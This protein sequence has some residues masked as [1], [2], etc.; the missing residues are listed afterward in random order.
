MVTVKR[1]W[2]CNEITNKK[3]LR[4]MNRGFKYLPVAIFISTAWAAQAQQVVYSPSMLRA[5]VPEGQEIDT[6]FFQ[7]GFD[8]VPGSYRFTLNVNGERHRV[9]TYELREYGN[10]LELVFQKKDIIDLPLKEKVIKDNFD[11]LNSDSEIF[12]ISSKLEGVVTTV[13]TQTMSIDISIP[14]IYLREDDGWVDVAPEDIW[15]YGETG[16]VINYNI[17][18]L[19]Q[20]SRSDHNDQSSLYS[21]LSGRLNLGPWR[22]YTSGAISFYRE[23][24]DIYKDRG[25]EWDLW[26]TYL[27]RDIPALKGTVEL[28]EITTSSEIFE[29]IPLRGLRLA[30][31]IQMLPNKDRTYAPIIEGIA[32]TNAQVLIRQNGH[33]VY[34]INVAAGPFRLENLPSFG[35]YGDLEVVIKEADGTERILNVPYSTVPNMLREGQFRYDLNFG[36]YYRK[37]DS[38][39]IDKPLVLLGTLSYGLPGDVTLY[40]GSL[41]SEGYYALALGTGLSLGKYGAL[42]ADV[43]QSKNQAD[44]MRG[45]REGNGAAWRVRYEKTLN[46]FGTTINLANYQYR[47]GNYM[48]MEDYVNYGRANS[49]FLS[50]HGR[51]KSRWQIAMSQNLGMY[52]SFTLGGDYAQY[53]GTTAD[54]KSITAGYGT[55]LKGIGVSVNYSRNYIKVGERSNLHWDSSHSI[56]LNLNIP[57]ALFTRNRANSVIDTTNI[58]YQARMD[59]SING[60]TTYRQSVVMNGFSDDN[61]WNWSLSQEMGDHKDR[62][63][64][65]SL[66]FNGDRF[67]AN[68]GIDHS[69]ISNSYQLGLNGALVFHKSGITSTSNA[70]DSIAIIE[71]PGTS[72]VKVSQYFDTKTDMFGNSVLS[73]L[74][75]YSKNE[76]EIDPATLPDGAILLD[77]S[78]KTVV[79]TAGAIV[80]VKYPIRFGRQ[81]VIILKNSEGNPIP[82]GSIV[83][84][85]DE[86]GT[87]DPYVS[88][89]VGEGGRVYMSGLPNKGILKVTGQPNLIFDFELPS[90]I[91]SLKEEFYEI[92]QISLSPK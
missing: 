81:A 6:S 18:G 85:L 54:I 52:G 34:T 8:I 16:A 12:P 14:Q 55:N 49:A 87:N 71:V 53:H 21:N 24:N 4:I 20:I 26:N 30:T 27:Q 9:G 36:R 76:I 70:Y 50:S 13:D 67:V 78:N 19:H 74:T 83:K 3:T 86:D 17:A 63:T 77:S 40:G 32:N 72:G 39:N 11:G 80:R 84:L 41:L 58:G 59:K 35:N 15:D 88:G 89:M 5:L 91:E 37:N 73:Y 38:S 43:V 47:T 44:T 23:D 92:P 22:L 1:W 56:M 68:A 33:L 29:S 51:I 66:S 2:L 46:D 10:K 57:L 75:N 60:E 45:L 65:A 48:T 62:S 25:H 69:K 31:N 7:K 61:K 90:K 28:G 82:F 79:P 64:S 42:A